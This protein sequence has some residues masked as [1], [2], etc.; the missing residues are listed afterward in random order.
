MKGNIDRIFFG[1][2]QKQIN[3]REMCCVVLI[4]YN[5]IRNISNCWREEKERRN[6][7]SNSRRN[8]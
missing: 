7:L 8:E 3:M 5:K 1:K 2:R 4:S 6:A